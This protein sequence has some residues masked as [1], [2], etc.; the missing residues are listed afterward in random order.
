[1]PVL[2]M[3]AVKI[4]TDKKK[5]LI[6]KLTDTAVEVTSLPASS[7]SVFIEEFDFDNMG[8]NGQTLSEKMS[9]K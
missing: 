9:N 1:M 8:S 6:K 3:K 4:S 5:E 2:I 7:F